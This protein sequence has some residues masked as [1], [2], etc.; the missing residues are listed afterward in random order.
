MHSYRKKLLPNHFDDYFIPMSSIHSLFSFGV[1]CIL[2]L[3]C[4]NIFLNHTFCWYHQH[5]HTATK[6]MDILYHLFTA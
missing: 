3:E 2:R 6:R 4:N 1:P 5:G